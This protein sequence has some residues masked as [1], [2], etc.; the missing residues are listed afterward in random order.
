MVVVGGCYF[1][2]GMMSPTKAGGYSSVPSG[3]GPE[4][5]T[6]KIFTRSCFCFPTISG[7]SCEH[8]TRGWTSGGTHLPF[9]FPQPHDSA[10]NPVVWF[11]LIHFSR[12]WPVQLKISAD[13]LKE[14][15][16]VLSLFRVAPFAQGFLPLNPCLC[17]LLFVAFHMFVLHCIWVLK[18]FL[19]E[20]LVYSKLLCYSQTQKIPSNFCFKGRKVRDTETQPWN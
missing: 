1:P 11:L 3:A 19:A 12:S 9:L 18:F 20:V 6:V 8:L 10:E 14:K 17:W 15:H 7:E 13:I 16:P 4:E 5:Y 2:A